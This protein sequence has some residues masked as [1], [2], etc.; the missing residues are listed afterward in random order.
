MDI[1]ASCARVQQKTSHVGETNRR[2]VSRVRVGAQLLWSKFVKA[3]ILLVLN[4]SNIV[5]IANYSQLTVTFFLLFQV[6][7][8]TAW[9]DFNIKYEFE[10]VLRE[11]IYL[12]SSFLFKYTRKKLVQQ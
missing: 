10:A 9:N 11:Q 4:R 8:V 5:F 1:R 12:I 6:R 3:S 7:N 2:K